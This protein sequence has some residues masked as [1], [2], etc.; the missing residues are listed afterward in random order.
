LR[1]GCTSFSAP[2]GVWGWKRGTSE[3]C[4]VWD[5]SRGEIKKSE[6]GGT[7]GGK[8]AAAPGFMRLLGERTGAKKEEEGGGGEIEGIPKP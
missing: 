7:S 1:G 2:A 3:Q 6:K 5:I 4:S 8:G